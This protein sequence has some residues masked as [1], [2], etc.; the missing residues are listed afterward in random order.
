MY[1]AFVYLKDLT[2]CCP[3]ENFKSVHEVLSDV[4]HHLSSDEIDTIDIEYGS[5]NSWSSMMLVTAD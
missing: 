3:K 1:R 2:I 5:D 4:Y